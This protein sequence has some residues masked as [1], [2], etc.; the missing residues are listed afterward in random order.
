M[1]DY[2][3]FNLARIVGHPKVPYYGIADKPEADAPSKKAIRRYVL[4]NWREWP[5]CPQTGKP[6]EIVF[7]ASDTLDNWGWRSS[8]SGYQSSSKY[9]SA[10][11]HCETCHGKYEGV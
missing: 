5:Y 4:H 9:L 6:V 11:F 3:A 1:K 2:C 7:C 8:S 10:F